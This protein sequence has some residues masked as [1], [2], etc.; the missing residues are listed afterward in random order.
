MFLHDIGIVSQDEPF[1]KL[2]N[3]GMILAKD[4]RKM[5]KS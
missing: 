5:S 4:G 1:Q 3:Q 2:I